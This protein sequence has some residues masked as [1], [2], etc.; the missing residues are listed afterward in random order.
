MQARALAVRNERGAISGS[1]SCQVGHRTVL[2]GLPVAPMNGA[3]V[4]LDY[5]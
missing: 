1:A 5:R 2:G 3:T 4:V